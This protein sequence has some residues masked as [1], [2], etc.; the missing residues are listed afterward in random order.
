ML[1]HYSYGDAAELYCCSTNLFRCIQFEG[2][3]VCHEH[4][5]PGLPSGFWMT[6][7]FR[8]HPLLY[9]TGHF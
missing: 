4:T 6:T 8:K 9:S 7:P 5:K 2:S 1:M 3:N